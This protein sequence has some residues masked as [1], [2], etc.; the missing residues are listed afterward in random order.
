MMRCLLFF[1]LLMNLAQAQPDQVLKSSIRSVRLFQQNNQG[2]LPIISLNSGEQLELHFDDMDAQVRNYAYTFQLCNADWSPAM[3]STFDYISG[4]TQQRILQFRP[5]SIAVSKYVHYQTMLPE[6][7]CMPNKSGNYLLKVFMDGDPNKPAFT[8]R[9]MVVDSRISIA[10]QVLQPFQ[11]EVFRTHQRIQ[12]ALN[13]GNMNIMSPQQQ[14]SVYVLQNRIWSN[15]RVV[16]PLFQRGNVLEFNTEQDLVFPGMKE[17][18][19]V[20][21]RSYRFVSDRMESAK[22]TAD[23]FDIVLKPDLPRPALRYAFYADRNGWSDIASSESLNPW[24]QTDYAQ[25]EFR[26][27]AEQLTKGRTLHI[28]SDFSGTTPTPANRLMYDSA[29]GMYATKLPLK[30]GY[31]WYQY[32][33]YDGKQV[34]FTPSE[35]NFWETEND[36]TIFVYFRSFTGRHDELMAVQS[37]NSRFGRR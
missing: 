3:L 5:S 29:S 34:D 26:Y 20:D 25:V 18:R 17:Y 1:L 33:V 14:L 7:N 9:M 12:L 6:R 19:W 16:K 30:Q 10:A 36:Y 4:F 21:L 11:P 27:A 15:M 37:I 31:Y 24:W 35:G 22:R 32:G 2:G 23:G 28:L 8:C 13:T